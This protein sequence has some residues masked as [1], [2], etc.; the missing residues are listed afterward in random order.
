MSDNICSSVFPIGS[1]PFGHPFEQTTH[2][3]FYHFRREMGIGH[4]DEGS[5][6]HAVGWQMVGQE[7]LMPT[8]GL[9]QLTL[10]AVAINGMLE[11]ALGDADENSG[12]Q[13]VEGGGWKV[14]F[15][16]NSNRKGNQ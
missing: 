11:M 4:P 8:V 9:A 3:P 16:D 13:R 10:A 7:S 15:I 1:Q 12:G 2:L 5:S 14:R 6:H